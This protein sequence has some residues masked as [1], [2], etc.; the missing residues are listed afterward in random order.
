MDLEQEEVVA[1]SPQGEGG[2]HSGDD[3]AVPRDGDKEDNEQKEGCN[4]LKQNMKHT[5]LIKPPWW[6]GCRWEEEQEAPQAPRCHSRT[7]E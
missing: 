7:G 2:T 6:R 5:S 3:Q 1:E 4:D